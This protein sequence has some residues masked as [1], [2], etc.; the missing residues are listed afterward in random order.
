MTTHS[1]PQARQP[2]HAPAWSTVAAWASLG[3]LVLVG[4][5]GA[6]GFE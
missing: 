6:V 3:L 2:I 1:L 4:F 5:A